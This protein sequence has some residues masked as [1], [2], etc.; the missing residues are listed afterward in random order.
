MNGTLSGEATMPLLFF[1]FF[2][3][4]GTQPLKNLLLSFFQQKVSVSLVIK[5]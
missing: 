2:L 1:F 3:L 4:N 5:L